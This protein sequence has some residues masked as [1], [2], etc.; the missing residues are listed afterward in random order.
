MNSTE[1][2]QHQLHFWIS[3]RFLWCSADGTVAYLLLSAACINQLLNCL[4]ID[5]DRRSKIK[6]YRKN[7]LRPNTTR[8]SLVL[9]KDFKVWETKLLTEDRAAA[10][11][12]LADKTNNPSGS[13]MV[14]ELDST[15]R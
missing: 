5:N 2:R 3:F 12:S 9:F 11:K 6:S 14:L 8:E 1:Y 10:K 4:R 15:Y 7:S 13:S